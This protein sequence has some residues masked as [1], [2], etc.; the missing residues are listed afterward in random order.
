MKADPYDN[1]R[2]ETMYFYTDNDTQLAVYRVDAEKLEALQPDIIVTQDHCDVCAVSLKDV[3]A[4]LCTW[5][6]RHVEI[7]SLKPELPR[8]HLGGYP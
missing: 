3:E 1:K 6:G 5:S 8:R 2:N 7:I 4:A